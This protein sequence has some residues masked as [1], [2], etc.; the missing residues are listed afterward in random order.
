MKY[1]KK[2]LGK[3]YQVIYLPAQAA[4]NEDLFPVFKNT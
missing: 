1:L 4:I 3:R 2:V